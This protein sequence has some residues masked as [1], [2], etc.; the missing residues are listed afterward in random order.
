[1]KGKCLKQLNSGKYTVRLYD[2]R[3]LYKRIEIKENYSGNPITI[4]DV[5]TWND[6]VATVA[7]LLS[8]LD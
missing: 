5:D 8:E 6:L 4:A 7:P 3:G 2:G 1:M